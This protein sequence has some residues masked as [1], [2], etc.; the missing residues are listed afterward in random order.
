LSNLVGMNQKLAHL[1]EDYFVNNQPIQ[2]EELLEFSTPFLLKVSE[3]YESAKQKV[4]IVGQETYTWNGKYGAFL[5]CGSPVEYGQGV[6]SNFLRKESENYNS[7]FWN[8]INRLFEDND[9]SWIWNNVFKLETV[10]YLSDEKYLDKEVSLSVL[11]K[12]KNYRH[13]IDKI[14]LLQKD[15]FLKEL[16]IL[17]PDVVIFFTGNPYDSLFMDWQFDTQNDFYQDIPEALEMGIDKWKFGRLSSSLLPVKTFRTYHPN[18]LRRVSK[19]IMTPEQ[20]DKIFDF[21]KAQIM[22]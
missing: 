21:L 6:Y 22:Q 8:Y 9:S 2:D 4:M 15:I 18:Y 3:S 17:K 14:K 10:E 7:P 5:S 11:S 19:K 1:Y 20:K 16:E 13:L 12:N